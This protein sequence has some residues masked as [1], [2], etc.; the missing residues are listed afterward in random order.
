MVYKLNTV[1]KFGK[2]RGKT[3]EQILK[4]DP[5]YI[6]WCLKNIDTFEMSK[7]DKE[8]ALEHANQADNER[9]EE[10]DWA[11]DPYDFCF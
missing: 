1:L 7:V 6:R 4:T 9:D 11:I 2:H 5:T 8:V 10:E 3:V